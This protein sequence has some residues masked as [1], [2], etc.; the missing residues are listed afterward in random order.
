MFES[1]SRGGHIR[2][3]TDRTAHWQKRWD[4]LYALAKQRPHRDAIDAMY[5]VAVNE[6]DNY[7]LAEQALGEMSKIDHPHS[8][9]RRL[10]FLIREA[11]RGATRQLDNSLNYIASGF[12]AFPAA[13]DRVIAPMCEAARSILAWPRKTPGDRSVQSLYLG[14]LANK[15]RL[16]NSAAAKQAAE[17]ILSELSLLSRR[18]LPLL[19]KLALT[20]NAFEDAQSAIAEIAGLDDP[21]AKDALRRIRR[22][23]DRMLTHTFV[24]DNEDVEAGYSPKTVVMQRSSAYLGEDL[25]GE[26]ATRWA[27]AGGS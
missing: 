14:K 20:A 4:A 16:V 17:R 12:D 7:L 24:T 8:V 6:P 11:P 26:A 22:A 2:I 23:P 10:E 27:A 19:E 5:A 15:I 18:D 13:G 25:T 21:Q 1:W 9:A 3:L